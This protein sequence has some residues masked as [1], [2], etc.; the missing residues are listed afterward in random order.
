MNTSAIY[1]AIVDIIYPVG[2]I[3][4]NYTD[5]TNPG[6]RIPGT[7]WIQI[8]D[9]FLVGEGYWGNREFSKGE[10]GGEETVALTPDNLPE[11]SHKIGYYDKEMGGMDPDGLFK[12]TEWVQKVFEKASPTE[13]TDLEYV[14]PYSTSDAGDNNYRHENMPPYIRV[15]GWYRIS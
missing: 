10:E 2:S 15:Y 8:E 12:S 3:I 9:K 1:T 4:Q 11:H 6:D 13:F 7:N 14:G 5:P